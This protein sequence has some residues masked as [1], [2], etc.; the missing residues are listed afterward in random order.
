MFKMRPFSLITSSVMLSDVK[1]LLSYLFHPN[2]TQKQTLTNQHNKSVFLMS[3]SPIGGD[4][5]ICGYIS[6]V[7]L[8]TLLAFIHGFIC[9]LIFS[10][11]TETSS[12][13][14]CKYKKKIFLATTEKRNP[15]KNK[16]K[17]TLKVG[18]DFIYHNIITSAVSKRKKKPRYYTISLQQFI[19]ESSNI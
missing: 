16:N 17:N 15:Q 3:L 9:F 14:S 8:I 11:K 12:K 7:I 4:F 5:L 6:C 18:S 19:R 13:T 10:T 2:Y 1:F